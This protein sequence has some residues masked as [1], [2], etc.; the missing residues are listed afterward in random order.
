MDDL[1]KKLDVLPNY[2]SQVINS[3]ENKTFYDLV[4]EERV[5]AF[6]QNIKKPASQQYTMLAIAFDCGF[7]SK[8]SFNRNFK[9]YTGH[10]PSEYVKLQPVLPP[11]PDRGSCFYNC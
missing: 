6:I 4:N 7:N 5:N 10:T 9:K 3:K 2:L 1:A 11:S 8:A